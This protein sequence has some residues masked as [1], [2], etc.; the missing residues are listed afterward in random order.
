MS[1]AGPFVISFK[2]HFSGHAADYRRARPRYPDALFDFLAG[3]AVRHDLAW[4]CATGNGQAALSLAGR[5][6]RVI[7]T[8]ASEQ[9]VAMAER[10]PGVEYRTATAEDSGLDDASVD[11]VTVAQALHWFDIEAFDRELRRVVRPGGVVAAWCYGMCSIEPACDRIVHRFYDALAQWWP[12]ERALVERGYRDIDLPG[13]P[14]DS[15]VF[16]MTADWRADDMLDY[17]RTWSA[18]QR[19]ARDTGADP[20]TAIATE[21]AAAWRNETRRVFWPLHLKV[22]RLA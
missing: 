20:V 7:A 17:V 19:C 15:P 22:S 21:L 13:A 8:D 2:D 11:L 14:L 10:V 4:D 18:T 5:F 12:P 3:A 9:Q 6:A 1:T 16:S